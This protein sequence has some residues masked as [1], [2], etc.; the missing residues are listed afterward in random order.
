LTEGV[1]SASFNGM[2]VLEI[3]QGFVPSFST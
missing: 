2:S 1:V 3:K